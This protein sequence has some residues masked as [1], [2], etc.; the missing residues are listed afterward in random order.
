[1]TTPRHPAQAAP[2]TTGRFSQLTYTS[3]S[4]P[5][6][7][8]AAARSGWQPK[9]Q[10]AD[11]T[12]S[13]QAAL[14]GWVS[15]QLDPVTPIPSF[16]TADDIALL[17]RR[18]MYAS[19]DAR[20]AVYC[21]TV[22][23]GADAAGRPGNVFAHILFDRDIGQANGAR[24]IDLW[25]SPDWLTPF[26]QANVAAAELD[27]TLERTRPGRA[28]DRSTVLEFLLSHETW[29]IGVL[30]V[31]LDAVEH[32]LRGGPRIVLAVDDPDTAA[33][34]IGAVSY[35]MSAATAA[36]LNWT[37]FD[38]AD[39]VASSITSGL[40]IVAV[41][42]PDSAAIQDSDRV[43]LIDATQPV[44]PGEFGRSEHHT[45]RGTVVPL[46]GWSALA[47][48]VL[49]DYATA[50]RALQRVD[51]IAARVPETS[52]APSWPLAMVVAENPRLHDAKEAARQIID[53]DSPASLTQDLVLLGSVAGVLVP[54]L[55]Y[56]AEDAWNALADTAIGASPGG[57]TRD[58][59][60]QIFVARALQDPQWLARE[61]RSYESRLLPE[62]G[63]G[64]TD[65]SGEV[66]GAVDALAHRA[67][68]AAADLAYCAQV[69]RTALR[70]LEL[71]DYA[72]LLGGDIAEVMRDVLVR[73]LRPVLYDHT[74]GPEFVSA[75][76][77]ITE[78]V[79]AEFVFPAV[80]PTEPVVGRPLGERFAGAVA[81]WLIGSGSIGFDALS[82][83][84]NLIE[85]PLCQ[86]V[87]DSVFRIYRSADGQLRR[88]WAW[89]MPIGLSRALYE[90]DSPQG[91]RTTDITPLFADE[92]WEVDAL[93]RVDAQWPNR[94][95]PRFFRLSLLESRSSTELTALIGCITRRAG[96]GRPR[97]TPLIGTP[98]DDVLDELALTWAKLATIDWRGLRR[99]DIDTLGPIL[100][101]YGQR[102][103]PRLPAP[104][105]TNVAIAYIL[106][107][108]KEA[109]RPT[110]SHALTLD[111]A[112]AD[113]L[114]NYA[115]QHRQATVDALLALIDR[116]SLDA[117]WVCVL[118][119]LAA[120][121]APRSAARSPDDPL[122]L[123]REPSG[124]TIFEEIAVQAMRKS[125]LWDAPRS[126]AALVEEVERELRARITE[127]GPLIH[128]FEHFTRMWHKANCRSG[129]R[130]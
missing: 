45:Q 87:S 15:T 4:A 50:D 26:G 76:G 84:R 6:V 12:D 85:T 78:R 16:P 88:D 56:T 127:P 95:P 24:P 48:T 64:P 27:P 70:M 19:P 75:I 108:S 114:A 39:S 77:S 72:G 118:A 110:A 68:V 66:R 46:T 63:H 79:R 36:R 54:A 10:T 82:R 67:Q 119:V 96:S 42:V 47:E 90:E 80:L 2:A 81:Q 20:S 83:N 89:A 116:A 126:E 37:T 43:V 98:S 38:R 14:V 61:Q 101:D 57:V 35:F 103:H 29:R 91:W 60:G 40:H 104:L 30:R 22:P 49:V 34:W 109:E 100:A 25:R 122:L 129:V 51:A 99:S 125:H 124:T 93:L 74:Y 59:V 32:S 106:W 65:L 117:H 94:I 58:F 120:P 102:P 52:L 128:D 23:A 55:G 11:L 112:H 107:R 69:A 111:S 31:L 33:L 121:S 41:P 105:D 113:A 18:L 1:M 44:Q 123:M 9:D 7:T 71:L 73:A 21:H 115:I 17:P 53:R 3:Y 97:S 86:L 8:G 13:E 130:Q 62:A 92:Q 5:S 28:I